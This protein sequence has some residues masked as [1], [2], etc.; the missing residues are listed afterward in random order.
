LLAQRQPLRASSDSSGIV[1]VGH[2]GTDA[3]PGRLVGED[4]LAVGDRLDR[5]AE[6]LTL[7]RDEEDPAESEREVETFEEAVQV[8]DE[9]DSPI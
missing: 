4:R 6:P 5:D 1:D 2:G 7:E 3:V 9:E 8:V